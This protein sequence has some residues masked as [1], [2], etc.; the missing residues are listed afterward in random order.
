MQNPDLWTHLKIHPLVAPDHEDAFIA[1]LMQSQSWSPAQARRAI[2]EY[3]RFL[4]LTQVMDSEATPSEPVDAVWHLHMTYTRDY[5]DR[6]CKGVLARA[7]HHLP[8][9]GE[10]EMPRFRAQY[11]ETKR[12]YALEFGEE[13]P[14]AFW[15]GPHAHMGRK[16][17]RICAGLSALFVVLY[18][19]LYA[20]PSIAGTRLHSAV[21]WGGLVAILAGLFVWEQTNKKRRNNYGG[22]CGASCGSADC[23]G[24]HCG[25]SGCGR[26]D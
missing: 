24:G 26:G 2:E 19:A 21:G 11:A 15:P 5:W 4:Y 1:K 18:A 20:V 9:G 8:G 17:A 6:L 13:P 12:W 22:T 3:R 7:L 14:L 25:G 16:V 10:A 23:G